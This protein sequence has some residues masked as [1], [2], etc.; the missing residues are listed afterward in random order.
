[1][2]KKRTGR[3]IIL[4]G[5]YGC[6]EFYGMA[7]TKK[8]AQEIIKECMLDYVCTLDNISCFEVKGKEIISNLSITIK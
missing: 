3:Y 1:M 8:E 7:D 6:E 5:S 4:Y 2:T